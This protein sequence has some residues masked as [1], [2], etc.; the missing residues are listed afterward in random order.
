MARTAIAAQAVTTATIITEK[1]IVYG[2]IR[3]SQAKEE[4]SVRIVGSTTI[5]YGTIHARETKSLSLF[6]LL[7]LTQQTSRVESLNRRL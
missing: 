6:L 7:L 1:T 4:E 5:K 2:N 3:Y